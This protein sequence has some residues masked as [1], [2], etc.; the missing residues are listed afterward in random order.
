MATATYDKIATQTLASDAITITF[1]SIPATYTDLRLV[2]VAKAGATGNPPV[3]IRLNSDTATNYS[4]TIL[5]GNGTA[6][7]SHSLANNNALFVGGYGV[8]VNTTY[9][10]LHTVDLFSYVGSTYKTV[11][12]TSSQDFNG[13]GEVTR[14]V[15]LWSSTAAITSILIWSTG[16]TSYFGIGTTATLYGIKNSL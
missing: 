11:L 3:Y 5:R 10:S 15:G 14:S 9:F 7:T 16:T 8:G 12:T 2:F 6:A 4:N 13:S 1:S